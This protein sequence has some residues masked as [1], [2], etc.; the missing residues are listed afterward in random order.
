MKRKKPPKPGRMKPL[1]LVVLLLLILVLLSLPFALWLLTPR[2]NLA[3]TV[4]DKSVATAKAE[5][6]Q[7]LGWFLSHNKFPT[8]EGKPFRTQSTYLGYHPR[9]DNPIRDL[10]T[11]D[12]KTDLLYIADTYGVYKSGEGFSRTL[13]EGESNLIWGGSS[14]SDVQAIKAFLNREASSTVVAEY[15]TFATPTP[16]YV[17]AQLYEVLGTRWTG[18]TGM[19]NTLLDSRPLQHTLELHGKRRPPVQH[20]Q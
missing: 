19:R 20:R 2:P 13:A 14:A 17:Q 4:Y 1:V 18:W 7:N 6:H 12:E 15:N 8:E 11:L 9:E 3:I 10:S 5:Q 16:S